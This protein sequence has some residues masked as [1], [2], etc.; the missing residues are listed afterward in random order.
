MESHGN[1]KSVI[2][3]HMLCRKSMSTCEISLRRM[4][5]NTFDDA[6]TLDQVM[7]SCHQATSHCL[8]QCWPGSMSPYGITKPQWVKKLLVD[9]CDLPTYILQGYFTG[10]GAITTLPQYKW[11]GQQP[12]H[13]CTTKHGQDLLGLSHC[14]WMIPYGVNRTWSTL[15]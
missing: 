9:L 8:S 7:A 15:V 2:S 10:T 5:Q 13:E 12:L 14:P 11:K 3:E 6:S 1:F 4:P